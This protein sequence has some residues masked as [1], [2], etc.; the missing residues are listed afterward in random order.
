MISKRIVGGVFVV[1]ASGFMGLVYYMYISEEHSKRK[2]DRVTMAVFHG[3]FC[4]LVWSFVHSSVSEPGV[5]PPYWGFYMGDSEHKRKR[6]CLLCH[7]QS[8]CFEHGPSLP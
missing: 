2:A 4:M 1:L 3:L 6:Y 8:L 5:V 7:L